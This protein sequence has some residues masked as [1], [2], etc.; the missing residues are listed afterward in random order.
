MLIKF[1]NLDR[2]RHLKCDQTLPSCVKCT[3]TGRTCDEYADPSKQ[4][5][6]SESPLLESSSSASSD[7]L[8]SGSRSTEGSMVMAMRVMPSM[9]VNHRELRA[10]DYFRHQSGQDPFS[11]LEGDFW[12]TFVL[13]MSNSFPAV[14][15]ALIAFSDLH[16]KY[17][18]RDDRFSSAKVYSRQQYGRAI[19]SLREHLGSASTSR[20][21]TEETL[22]ICLLFVCFEVLQGNDFAALVHLEAA[23]GIFS[24]LPNSCPGAL[25]RS[26]HQGTPVLPALAKMF[27][28][29]DNQATN[30]IGSRPPS[31]VSPD[32][33]HRLAIISEVSQ[34]SPSKIAQARDSLHL[35]I[36]CAHDYLRSTA[37]SV[38]LNNTTIGLALAVQKKNGQLGSLRA[39]IREYQDLLERI[40]FAFENNDAELA[41]REEATECAVLWLAYLVTYIKLS[42]SLDPDEITYDSYLP[43]FRAII[44][45]SEAVLGQILADE[46]ILSRN[47]AASPPRKLFTIE[48]KFIHPLYFT[49]F[50]CRDSLIRQRAIA[51][52]RVAGKEGAWDGIVFARIAEHVKVLEEEGAPGSECGGEGNPALVSELKRVHSVGFQ[53]NREEKTI[54]VQCTLKAPTSLSE[55]KVFEGKKLDDVLSYA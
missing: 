45:H 31:T 21:V 3:S 27:I 29:L 17:V 50:K 54:W 32:N 2:I 8:L 42:T 43:Q 51:L 49:A 36:S 22:L 1:S 34:S 38:D 35:C 30:L 12:R 10:I 52:M 53:I 20:D 33:I 28:R 48:E 4:T 19:K 16:E 41:N 46:N 26:F 18:L 44:E 5:G 24:N 15:H 13:Q 23:L 6:A 25:T 7:T 55:N 37:G 14:Q 39:W 9:T 40:S 11:A 47:D